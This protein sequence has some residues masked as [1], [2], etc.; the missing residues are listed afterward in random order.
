M[1]TDKLVGAWTLISSIQSCNNV[2]SRTYG[3]PPS[4]QLQYT[5]DGRMSAFLMN[6]D[7]AR[8]GKRSA[9]ES[10]QFFAY[11]GRWQLNENEIQH[12]IEFSSIPVKVGTVFVR[13]LK[14]L[15]ENEMELVTKPETTKSGKV[16]ETKLV[17]R[18]HV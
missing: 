7:W 2:I 13:Y 16:Y 18:R 15:N 17:W 5:N 12:A 4:G 8:D 1:K 10:D 14:F 3:D 9:D 11:A 6:P